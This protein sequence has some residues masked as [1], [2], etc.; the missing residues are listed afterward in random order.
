MLNAKFNASK[1]GS[2]RERLD[3]LAAMEDQ[4][5]ETDKGFVLKAAGG[6]VGL[7]LIL[8]IGALATGVFDDLL[9]Q[10]M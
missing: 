4:K 7:C 3:K 9:L 2:K 8:C 1:S 6:F 10:A 5:I